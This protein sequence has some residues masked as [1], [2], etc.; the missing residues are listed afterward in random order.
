[1]YKFADRACEEGDSSEK[2]TRRREI[3][4]VDGGGGKGG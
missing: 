1:M 2:R 3:C 4:M